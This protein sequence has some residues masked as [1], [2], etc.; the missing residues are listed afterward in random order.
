MSET[1]HLQHCFRPLVTGAMV[2]KNRV[3]IHII[4]QTHL[5]VNNYFRK[6]AIFPRTTSH[7]LI[8]RFL[9]HRQNDRCTLD[10]HL[11]RIELCGEARFPLNGDD[12]DTGLFVEP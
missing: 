5:R 10:Q 8:Q 9:L 2:P 6:I 7:K 3:T 4:V 11:V 12:G 1:R